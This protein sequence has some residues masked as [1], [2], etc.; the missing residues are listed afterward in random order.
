MCARRIVWCCR[1]SSAPRTSL[2]CATRISLSCKGDLHS[3]ISPTGTIENSPVLQHWKGGGTGASPGG[4]VEAHFP[5]CRPCRDWRSGRGP[6]QHS[7]AGLFSCVPPGQRTSIGTI[8]TLA[9]GHNGSGD[10]KKVRCAHAI[11][12]KVIPCVRSSDDV[13]SAQLADRNH[14]EFAAMA[15]RDGRRP[16]A[17]FVAWPHRAGQ[18]RAASSILPFRF[19]TSESRV[20][21]HV[22]LQE[23]PARRCHTR[24]GVAGCLYL[25]WFTAPC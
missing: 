7:S 3:G 9:L 18:F 11:A 17:G 21:R 15:C 16:D 1:G 5:V 4:T 23:L 24:R 12:A 8:S 22:F 2:W 20:S 6:A 25:F 19:T 14:S 13:S 10:C